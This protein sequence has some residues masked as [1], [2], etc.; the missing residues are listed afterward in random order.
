MKQAIDG[1]LRCDAQPE[2]INRIDDVVVFNALNMTNIEPI[3]DS[4]A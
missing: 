3:V 4:A 2:F 1:A